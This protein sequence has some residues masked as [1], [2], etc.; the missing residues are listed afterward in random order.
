MDFKIAESEERYL[1]ILMGIGDK[2]EGG[3]EY[4]ERKPEQFE[5]FLKDV[6]ASKTIPEMLDYIIGVHQ[7]I[8]D[9][10]KQS[11]PVK[12]ANMIFTIKLHQLAWK[13]LQ[14]ADL[15]SKTGEYEDDC[16]RLARIITGHEP[17]PLLYMRQTQR[18]K[19]QP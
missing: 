8:D 18:L 4:L 7:Q 16:L 10:D 19:V 15:S 2:Y 3:A 12:E 13:R 14:I 6:I 11:A 17:V 5:N 9:N 1:T